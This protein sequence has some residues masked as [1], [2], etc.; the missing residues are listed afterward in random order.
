MSDR[1][2]PYERWCAWIDRHRR[3]IFVTTAV[4][5]LCAAVLSYTRLRLDADVLSMLPAGRPAF[6][7]FK[8]FVADFG[9]LNEL[10]VLVEGRSLDEMKAFGDAF[11]ARLAEL[12]IVRSVHVR[13]DVDAIREGILNRRLY[14][15]LPVAAYDRLEQRLTREGI[16]AQVRADRAILSAPFDLEAAR[17]VASD[18]LGLVPLAAEQLT[19]AR[20]NFLATDPAGYVVAP[21]RTALL[22]FVEPRESAFDIYFSETLMREVKAAEAATRR[23]LATTAVRVAYTGSYVYALEDA[24]TL[25]R[26]VGRY[27][28]LALIGV[29]ASFFLGYGH[30]RLLPYFVVPLL[31]ATLVDFALSVIVFDQL[32]VVSLSFAA[33]LYGL[34]IDSGIH[35][36]TRLLQCPREQGGAAV[37]TTLRALGR[38]HV[39]ASL[40]TASAFFLIGLSDLAGLRQLGLM[41][42]VGMLLTTVQFFTLYPALGFVLLE[43]GRP[44][45]AAAREPAAGANRRVRATPSS[46][47]GRFGRGACHRC[48]ER[49]VP[50]RV[51]RVARPPAAARFRCATRRERDRGALRGARLDRR[52]TRASRQGRRCARRQRGRCAQSRRAEDRRCR[53]RVP[54]HHDR[55]AVRTHT[56]RAP[57]TLRP[58]AARAGK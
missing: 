56:A 7:D 50:S 48:C 58:A 5:C 6:D 19:G 8:F 51:R 55:A 28:I 22:I 12:D 43:R 1:G 57:S 9:E 39:G 44:Q 13:T 31:A 4:L 17:A 23:A 37:A 32:N 10:T 11:G 3:A 14:N 53:R 26:D 47:L 45:T 54:E 20:G 21:D 41:T 18:P 42:G 15:Y 29:L 38:A 30:L 24:D 35:F 34:S 52:D 25:A 33:I 2:F 49:G 16:A 27:T 46:L 40:T 36:Y